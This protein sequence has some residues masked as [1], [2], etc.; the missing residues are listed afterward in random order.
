MGLKDLPEKAYIPLGRRGMEAFR[1]RECMKC[2]NENEDDLQLLDRQD[3]T[4]KEGKNLLNIKTYKIK[5]NK[6]GTTYKIIIK[7]LY[8]EE[9]TEENRLVSA[10]HYWE[11]GEEQWLG[12]F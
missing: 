2:G 12:V 9:Q 3:V 5:C 8:V 11:N 1:L 7:S 6:C 4:E 10:V